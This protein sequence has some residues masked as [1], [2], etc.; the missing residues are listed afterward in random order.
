MPET[1]VPMEP[2]DAAHRFVQSMVPRRD[3]L[4]HTGYPYWY[5]WAL[6]VAFVAGA[7]WMEEQANARN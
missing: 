7:K 3:N 1:N 4:D 6:R 2:V 5:G